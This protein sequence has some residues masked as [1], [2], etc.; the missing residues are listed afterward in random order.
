M[1]QSGHPLSYRYLLMEDSNDIHFGYQEITLSDVTAALSEC[2]K[3]SEAYV[4]ALF[5]LVQGILSL[6]QIK[7]AHALEDEETI[8]VEDHV[9]AAELLG[10]DA[11]AMTSALTT[12]TLRDNITIKCSA[13]QA[14]V[15][16]DA[17][18][19]YLYARMFDFLVSKINAALNA[20][21]VFDDYEC[22]RQMVI[23]ILDMFG[24][25]NLAYNGLEQLL[26]NYANEALHR[27]YLQ[28]HIIHLQAEYR[29]EGIDGVV[30][31][32]L[33][34]ASTVDN[35]IIIECIEHPNSGIFSLLHEQ[36][37]LLSRDQ[38]LEYS[39]GG[40]PDKFC[41]SFV[42]KL[43][44][45]TLPAF[46]QV[47]KYN[48]LS[49]RFHIAHF[50]SDV[51][52]TADDMLARNCYVNVSRFEGMLSQS[53]NQIAGEIFLGSSAL[54][55]TGVVD[56]IR[57]VPTT[58][59]C[60]TFKQQIQRLLHT[61]GSTESGDHKLYY[62]K[63]IKANDQKRPLLFDQA[64][65]T[66]QVQYS[67][68][69][70]AASIDK[71]CFAF[72]HTYASLYEAFYLLFKVTNAATANEASS[73]FAKFGLSDEHCDYALGKNFVYLSRSA[74]QKLQLASGAI[75]CKCAV[76]C[77]KMIRGYFQRK[78]YR[79]ILSNIIS[80]QCAARCLQA[81][82]K[83]DRLRLEHCSITVI[84]SYYRMLKVHRWYAH[85]KWRVATLQKTWRQFLHSKRRQK[86]C[87]DSAVLIQAFYRAYRAFR[88]CQERQFV[89]A[90]KIQTAYLMYKAR[91]RRLRW[92][93]ARKIYAVYR[94]YKY[95][96]QVH[97]NLCDN[98]YAQKIQK[99][100]R[101][102][103]ALAQSTRA[104]TMQNAYWAHRQRR[105]KVSSAA[106]TAT[107]PSTDHSHMLPVLRPDLSLSCSDV[108]YSHL[109]HEV[110]RNP[111]FGEAEELE[112]TMSARPSSENT[113]TGRSSK[114]LLQQSIEV[115]YSAWQKTVFDAL[116]R[117]RVHKR[118][119][120]LDLVGFA[121]VLY[122]FSVYLHFVRLP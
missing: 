57:N 3:F 91:A 67:G 80:V 108:V 112:N 120:V 110:Y 27:I 104:R 59:I 53:T 60:K 118:D 102:H 43:Q 61:I 41:S 13:R 31:T 79:N 16:T 94:A 100:Y 18:A 81:R 84:Q 106:E 22:G 88:L 87:M 95:S 19:N 56:G 73:V 52:Y 39:S 93:S 113:I 23:N 105:V 62:L 103:R 97:R 107:T 21:D 64:Y 28:E 26:I 20:N 71:I 42:S 90:R 101:T 98:A 82:R 114:T 2:L 24:F 76:S 11:T 116:E 92:M 9:R 75:L 32:H 14:F 70:P 86:L 10:L 7:F 46:S 115:A 4:K 96:Q 38:Q 65:V 77:Q 5:S 68:L 50:A 37:L 99:A 36:S 1:E 30:P 25:E 33:I 111:S 55:S 72:K 89:S 63:C 17:L 29:E 58:T 35:R 117:V 12:V 78:R 34:D 40:A 8:C 48:K 119:V 66:Q 54:A 121:N 51:Q 6:G 45:S 69:V 122:L 47:L 85:V 49:R 83:L 15:A 109:V 74:M 44:S